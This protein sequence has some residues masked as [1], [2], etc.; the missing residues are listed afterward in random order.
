[1]APCSHG[2]VWALF[3]RN[4]CLVQKDSLGPNAALTSGGDVMVGIAPNPVST[5][6]D[7]TASSMLFPAPWPLPPGPGIWDRFPVA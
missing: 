1:M 5:V 2:S 3:A 4:P 7:R 6:T